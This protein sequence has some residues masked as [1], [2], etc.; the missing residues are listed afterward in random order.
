MQIGPV[1]LEMGM[2]ER[3][4]HMNAA[5]PDVW[6]LYCD[7]TATPNPGKIGVGILLISPQGVR[8]EVSRALHN[9]CNNEAEAL[10]LLEGMRTALCMGAKRLLLFSDSRVIVDHVTGRMRIRVAA[11]AALADQVACGLTQFEASELRWLGQHR[12]READALARHA[13]GL[14]ART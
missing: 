11:L 14:S 8:T 3:E 10:A 6:E 12:N 1:I 4:E 5:M 7:G 2:S 13:L 9:G